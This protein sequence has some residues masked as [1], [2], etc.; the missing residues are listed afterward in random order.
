MFIVLNER[1]QRSKTLHRN[2]LFPLGQELQCE[3]INQRVEVSDPDTETEHI[4]ETSE[5]SLSKDSDPEVEEKQAYKDPVTRAKAKALEQ[6]NAF[7]VHY[8]GT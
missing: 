8:I 6:A 1:S 7:M 4:K 2:I 5:Q 3:D